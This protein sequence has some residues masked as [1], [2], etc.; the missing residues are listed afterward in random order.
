MLEIV[1][2]PDNTVKIPLIGTFFTYCGESCEILSTTTYQ[3]QSGPNS[4]NPWK[5]V[6]TTKALILRVDD[7]GEDLGKEAIWVNTDE[8]VENI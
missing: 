8:L 4:S 6:F 7:E 5:P 2:N 1:L 3:E